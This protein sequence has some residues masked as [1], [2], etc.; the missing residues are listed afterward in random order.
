MHWLFSARVVG[1]EVC[2]GM[3]RQPFWE[4]TYKSGIYIVPSSERREDKTLKALKLR[5]V[6]CS[7]CSSVKVPLGASP[8]QRRVTAERLALCSKYT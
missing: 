1:R 5:K 6:D 8:L 7:S 4:L 3:L 2:N